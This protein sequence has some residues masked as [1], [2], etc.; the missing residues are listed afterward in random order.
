MDFELRNQLVELLLQ[1]G[2]AHHTAYAATDGS[3]RDWPIWYADYLQQPLNKQ[4][5]MRFDKSQLIY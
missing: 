4:L 3:D 5:D 2:S 1:A